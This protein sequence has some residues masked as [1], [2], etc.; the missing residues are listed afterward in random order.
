MATEGAGFF[1]AF[2]M[3]R[4]WCR[5]LNE[6]LDSTYSVEGFA[7]GGAVDR[8]FQEDKAEAYANNR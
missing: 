2:S 5:E 8:H 7:L 3:G 6:I 4:A 1:P